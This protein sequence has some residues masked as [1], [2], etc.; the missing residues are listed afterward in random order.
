MIPASGA[1]LTPGPRAEEASHK[2]E[3]GTV[4]FSMQLVP[5]LAAQGLTIE[6]AIREL[7]KERSQ[8]T[9]N[10]RPV[11]PKE[12]YAALVVARLLG[13]VNYAAPAS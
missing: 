12:A 6:D 5:T 2:E 13:W 7:T 9:A 1:M 10:A 8:K 4:P 11:S 3:R